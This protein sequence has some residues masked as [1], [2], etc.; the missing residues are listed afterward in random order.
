M[1]RIRTV[2]LRTSFPPNILLQPLTAI[3]SLSQYRELVP[4]LEA[5]HSRSEV[6]FHYP[7]RVLWT[8][9]LE[10]THF[11]RPEDWQLVET[12]HPYEGSK[13]QID[14]V[15]SQLEKQALQLEEQANRPAKV[16]HVMVHPGCASTG[17]VGD[18][19]PPILMPLMTY[20]FYLVRPS[21]RVYYYNDGSRLR[22]L[23][24][25]PRL[26]GSPHHPITPHTAGIAA[27]HTLLTPLENLPN[28]QRHSKCL[29][30]SEIHCETSTKEQEEYTEVKW[31]K[32][33]DPKDSAPPIKFGAETDFYGNP[34]V[35]VMRVSQW[36]EY[37]PESKAL[38]D[39]FEGMYKSLVLDHPEKF[40]P[41]LESGTDRAADGPIIQKRR[42]WDH[43]D[44]GKSKA[45]GSGTSGYN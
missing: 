35:G 34:R 41:A 16:R 10:A 8:S 20:S 9:S 45:R 42:G 19:V 17:I 1:Q 7:S 21:L 39:R 44:G 36:K 25:K 43:E 14:L 40:A 26:L 30:F 38:V 6:N 15:A 12:N 37:E 28:P 32:E 3:R 23:F 31:I 2:P 4:L 18:M 13:Y 22:F 11:Y 27:T 29:K 5:F 33:I 24:F